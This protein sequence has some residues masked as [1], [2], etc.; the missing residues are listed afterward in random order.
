MIEYL[1][2][3]NNTVGKFQYWLAAHLGLLRKDTAYCIKGADW[4]LFFAHDKK[5]WIITNGK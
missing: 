4:M 3:F 2:F 5:K 1:T